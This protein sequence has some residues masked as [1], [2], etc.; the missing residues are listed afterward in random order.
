MKT[1]IIVLMLFVSLNANV[2]AADGNKLLANCNAAIATI[3]SPS[4]TNVTF[5]AGLCFGL[6]QGILHMSQMYQVHLV[7]N[8]RLERKNILMCPPI[9][10]TN[11]QAA[12]I[13]VKYLRDHPEEL[14]NFDTFLAFN[15][16]ADAFPCQK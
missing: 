2:S 1:A 13:V 6:M 14:H 9:S 4:A 10:V 8:M 16:L 3:D 12:R 5:G 15:A 7:D 11:G